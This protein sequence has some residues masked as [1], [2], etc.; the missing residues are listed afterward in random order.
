MDFTTRT[1]IE[2]DL[3]EKLKRYVY[4]ILGCC[5]EVHKS[6]GPYLN[7]YMYQDA[8]EICFDDNNIKSIREFPIRTSFHGKEINHHHQADFLC[9]EKVILECKSV[10]NLTNEHRQQLW[11][12]MRLSGKRIGILYNF[13]PVKDQC[14]RY[15]YDPDKK[16]I[17]AF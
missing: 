15:Y 13:A 7:E 2:P 11:N 8:L 5:Q 14:E 16:S 12:Y 17:A 10:A 1:T 4:D 3:V 6:L 9:K